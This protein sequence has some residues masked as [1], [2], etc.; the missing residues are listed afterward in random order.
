MLPLRSCTRTLSCLVIVYGL[1]SGLG[2]AAEPP[3]RSYTLNEVV[4]VALEHNPA[5]TAARAELDKS[6]GRQEMAKAYPNPTFSMSAGHGA[7]R[8]PSTGVSITERTFTLEQPLEWQG[9]RSARQRAAA[10]GLNSA[11]AAL[12]ETRLEV[13]SEV[14]VAF[15]TMLLAQRR[16]DLAGEN[17]VMVEKLAEIVKTRVAAG[18][19][20]RFE[21]TKTEVEVLKGRQAL[22]KARSGVIMA[23][24]EV[25][26]LTAGELGTDFTVEGEFATVDDVPPLQVL[27]ARAWE[28]H[29]L[30]RRLNRQVEQ[31]DHQ[32]VHEQQSRIPNVTVSGQYHREAGD[33]AFTAGLSVPVPV[34][35]RQQGEIASAYGAKRRAEADLV[36]ARA[37]LAKT[38]TQHM[39]EVRTA[40]DQIRVFEEGLLK[41]AQKTVDFARISFQ[42]GYAGLLDTLDAQRVYRETLNDYAQAKCELAT[43]LVRLERS[44]GGQL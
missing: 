41:Q 13:I 25:N 36:H 43:A 20:T 17:V 34:W 39:Q 21:L 40:R 30:T 2:L 18:D 19:A 38:L 22:G 44:V 7:I 15:Y 31:A 37:D 33:E 12:E 5:I 29:P 6:E 23:R 32:V 3:P 42:Q 26:A 14:K 10:A 1:S 4:R 35:Y 11:Q 24:A 28:Q 8:D 9:K 16:A 27:I